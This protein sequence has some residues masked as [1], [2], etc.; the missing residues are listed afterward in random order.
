MSER[1]RIVSLR[2]APAEAF[3]PGEAT[4]SRPPTSSGAAPGSKPAADPARAAELL[5]AARAH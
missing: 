5:R 4:T 3:E 1:H 2:S